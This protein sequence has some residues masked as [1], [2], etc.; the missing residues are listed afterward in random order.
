LKAQSFIVFPSNSIFYQEGTIV[1][2]KDNFGYVGTAFTIGV[3]G[4]AFF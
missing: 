3:G 4:V 1:I 2:S